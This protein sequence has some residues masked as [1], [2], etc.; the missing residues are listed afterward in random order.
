MQPNMWKRL[1]KA[2]Q[3]VSMRDVQ[4]VR[5]IQAV[6]ETEEEVEDRI[7]RWKAGDIVPEIKGE[8]KGGELSIC[9]V[10]IVSPSERSD[11]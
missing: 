7:S 10:R 1:N 11:D 5:V 9:W 6:G 2:G 4:I 3:I 8:Y